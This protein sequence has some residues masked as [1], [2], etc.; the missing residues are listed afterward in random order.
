[1]KQLTHFTLV[2][3]QTLCVAILIMLAAGPTGCQEKEAQRAELV[4]QTGHADNAHF[5]SFFAG[6]EIPRH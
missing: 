3:A 5:F 6:W 2:I 1:M 4:V